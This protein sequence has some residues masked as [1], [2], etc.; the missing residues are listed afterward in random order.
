MRKLWPRDVHSLL[1]DSLPLDYEFPAG[2][3]RPD[4][5]FSAGHALERG[6]VRT[7][8]PMVLCP[9]AL[10][11]ARPVGSLPKVRRRV[12]A[13]SPG[14]GTETRSA[15]GRLWPVWGRRYG[16][17]Q[18]VGDSDLRRHASTRQVRRAP[19]SAPAV[20]PLHAPR[21]PIPRPGPPRGQSPHSSRTHPRKRKTKRGRT[22]RWW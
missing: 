11:L 10:P 5:C 14:P 8:R 15:T 12:V 17:S 2:T 22:S 18:F 21:C 20:K 9:P 16:Q 19:R 6:L 7:L 1:R 4:I 3:E 13:W